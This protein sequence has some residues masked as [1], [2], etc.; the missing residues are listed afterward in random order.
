[1]ASDQAIP[2]T[3][4]QEEILEQFRG[5]VFQEGILR[6]GDSIGTDDWTLLRFLRARKFNIN[7]AKMMMKSAQHWRKT[8]V[9]VG[10]DE[11]Y[12][13]L[14][15]YDYPNREQ[16][17]KF[18]SM[19]FHKLGRPLNFEFL[20]NCDLPELYKHITPEKHWEA[21]I[22]MTEAL[23]REV[24]PAASRAAGRHIK[25]SF[26][27]V[28][29]K[30]FGLF[31]FWQ[32]KNLV[33]ESFQIYQD[34]YPEAMAKL[35]IVNAPSSFAFIWSIIKPWLAKETTE[36]IDILGPDYQK[37]LLDL[38][39][40]ESL[41]TALGGKCTCESAGGCELSGAGPWKDERLIQQTATNDTVQGSSQS[42]SSETTAEGPELREEGLPTN[43]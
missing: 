20:G 3:S 21:I 33:Q 24:L 5:Q 27:I 10:I 23:T 8:A 40:A 25:G 42:P 6:E 11:L 12:K 19:F 22:V 9:G 38:I 28:D 7:E 13:T 39:D 30:G 2:L 32:V 37:V 4:Q 18:W 43:S 1:M 29:L 16:V 31:Q 36:K 26:V 14:D 17:F 34:Y 41:P 15:L 35:A